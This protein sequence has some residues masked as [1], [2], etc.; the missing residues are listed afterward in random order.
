VRIFF[1]KHKNLSRSQLHIHS[2]LSL[3]PR[4][5][6]SN[7]ALLDI[8]VYVFRF[9]EP[10]T[11]CC[12]V[13]VF[14]FVAALQEDLAT[15][16]RFIKHC[17]TSRF[18][19]LRVRTI[20]ALLRFVPEPLDAYLDMADQSAHAS[21]YAWL[22]A[23]VVRVS[24]LY[25][26]ADFVAERYG[27]T[28][29]T[30]TVDKL[31][32]DKAFRLMTP[33][34]RNS[35]S[36]TASISVGEQFIR[37]LRK[38]K[39][40][41][42]FTGSH[43]KADAASKQPHLL[44]TAISVLVGGNAAQQAE[45]VKKMAEERAD[46]LYTN[47]VDAV[48][49]V[50]E[51]VDDFDNSVHYFDFA[52]NK[53]EPIGNIGRHTQCPA[54]EL[55]YHV[56]CA[57]FE[58]LS[59]AT[60]LLEQQCHTDVALQRARMVG[61]TAAV[62]LANN[63]YIG[64]APSVVACQDSMADLAP[65]LPYT[66]LLTNRQHN[67]VRTQEISN[68]W[69]ER[70]S[71]CVQL[72]CFVR[73]FERRLKANCKITQYMRWVLQCVLICLLG[74]YKHVS[75]T[76][77]VVRFHHAL[78]LYKVFSLDAASRSDASRALAY[79]LCTSE[80]VIDTIIRT[81]LRENFAVQL[82]NSTAFCATVQRVWQCF[83][84]I[85]QIEIPHRAD[86]ARQLLAEHMT[87]KDNRAVEALYSCNASLLLD[88]ITERQQKATNKTAERPIVF[89]RLDDSFPTLAIQEFEKAE[90]EYWTCEIVN[91]RYSKSVPPI[92]NIIP[93]Q[94]MLFIMHRVMA[95]K[96][97]E[98]LTLK[99]LLDV[100]ISNRCALLMYVCNMMYTHRGR[101]LDIKPCILAM[102]KEYYYLV[103]FVLHV[104]RI[105]QSVCID[106][107]P[108]DMYA[109]QV[110][111][112]RRRA[113]M[114]KSD[115]SELPRNFS[116]IMMCHILGCARPCN[117]FVPRDSK[118]SYGTDNVAYSIRHGECV[119]TR[120]RD[121]N[122]LTPVARR[123]NNTDL[124]EVVKEYNAGRLRVL[125]SDQA[126][127]CEALERRVWMDNS[128]KQL[129]TSQNKVIRTVVGVM[130][131]LA[132]KEDSVR[133]VPGVGRIVTISPPSKREPRH[134]FAYCE[135]CGVLSQHSTD[136]YIEGRFYC[137]QCNYQERR[138]LNGSTCIACAKFILADEP[139]LLLGE[140]EA[141]FRGLNTATTAAA[142]TAAT[143]TPSAP[144]AKQAPAAKPPALVSVL[145]DVDRMQHDAKLTSAKPAKPM[146]DYKKTAEPSKKKRTVKFTLD[147]T[148]IDDMDLQ[149]LNPSEK[150]KR[151]KRTSAKNDD[152]SSSDD[153]DNSDFS[154]AGTDTDNDKSDSM[155]AV[156][157]PTA[158]SEEKRSSKLSAA[159]A[160]AA[161]T[162][163]NNNNNNNRALPKVHVL[164]L[165]DDRPV[166]GFQRFTQFAV[167][168]ECM[169]C[170]K[171]PQISVLA[172]AAHIKSALK[173]T[174]VIKKYSDHQVVA[175]LSKTTKKEKT[176]GLK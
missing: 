46:S 19:K 100:G 40:C 173:D 124:G 85:Q 54:Q 86:R 42:G 50:D 97:G 58:H 136:R 109:R 133:I 160:V 142:A 36:L 89:R 13:A 23:L 26:L 66:D 74:T 164:P 120:R 125:H 137:G 72:V 110:E 103:W 38:H 51:P 8:L 126:D 138:V 176:P 24:V 2:A 105:H 135:S 114:P 118:D 16:A 131:Q 92:F 147:Q 168:A 151:Y 1:S 9:T 108:L 37:Y 68:S 127:L 93:E 123:L 170:I 116:T 75:C 14:L 139:F 148:D 146:Q 69:I 101:G 34:S 76:E 128:L 41:A 82:H 149:R 18:C 115:H 98:P 174:R 15:S 49:G 77:P 140:T 141:K 84:E 99:L 111:A 39:I 12:R 167:C 52:K 156:E 91:N 129:Q 165:Y 30:N 143:T 79:Q 171:K 33:E 121:D 159:G 106:R 31:D 62:K 122:V 20:K 11:V 29:Q 64:F 47:H 175:A 83:R 87:T 21:A 55:A 10:L 60:A 25:R 94:I 45:Q 56:R 134:C 61:S 53:A 3:F 166:V 157:Q 65:L 152:N 107:L 145:K 154:F 70:I 153:E 57:I 130:F 172:L 161:G 113:N 5:L 67:D 43:N 158:T 59:F 117:L 63:S 7:A 102:P 17:C 104:Y 132:C 150:V 44:G 81:A 35:P 73:D 78:A 112:I 119:C 95:T 144:T 48:F 162:A 22:M 4:L 28:L 88:E 27:D 71:A 6:A 169:S 32:K 96:R 155:S 90:I 163:N 80:A